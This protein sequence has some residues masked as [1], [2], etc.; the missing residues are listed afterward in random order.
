[1]YYRGTIRRREKGIESVFEEIIVENFPKLGE[2]T[3]SQTMEAHR[4]PYAR[5]PR[6]TTSRHIMI[7][8]AMIKDKDRVLKA[9]RERKRS[10][11]KKTHQNIIRILSRNLIG[12]EGMA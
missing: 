9:A 6:K 11:P 12:Q 3:V 2:E 8:M 7:K 10:P 1:M 4:T 5:D